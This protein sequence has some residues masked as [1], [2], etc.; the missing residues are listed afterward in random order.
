M[1]IKPGHTLENPFQGLHHIYANKLAEKG[2]KKDKVEHL[3]IDS[4]WS[5]NVMVTM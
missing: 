2:L 3:Q 5:L 4:V 1:L